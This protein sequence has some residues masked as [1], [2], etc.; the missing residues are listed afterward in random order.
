A[1]PPPG[2][3][4]D[5]ETRVFEI[6]VAAHAIDDVA[7]DLARAAE[8]GHRVSLGVEQL[9]AQ[10]LVRLRLLLDRAVRPLIEP[11]REAVAAEVVEAAHPLGAVVAHPVLT[12]EL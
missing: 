6:E 5:V 4:I 9:A 11:G 12:R 7:A 2:V 3:L 8:P 10:P 1:R